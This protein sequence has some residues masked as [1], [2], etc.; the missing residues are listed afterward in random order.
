VSII[1]TGGGGGGGGGHDDDKLT[2]YYR[3]GDADGFGDPVAFLESASQAQGYVTDNTDCNDTDAAVNPGAVEACSDGIDNDCDGQIDEGCTTCTDADADGYY[4][5]TGCGTAVDC[6]DANAAVR[7]GAAEV[8]KDGID[9]DCD[10]QIDEDCAACTDAD[11]DGYYAEDGCGNAFLQGIDCDDDDAAVHP[12]AT[13]ICHDGIDNNCDGKI[14]EGCTSDPSDPSDCTDA[15]DDNYYAE[16]GCGNAIFQG[17]DCDDN[18]AAVYPGAKEVCDDGIDNDCDGKIDEGCTSDPSACTDA[19]RDGYF[20]EDGCGNAFL[21]GVDCD[22]DN[23]AV[24]PDATEVCDGIDN[25]CDGQVDENCSSGQPSCTDADRDGYY[26]EAGCGTAVDCNDANAAVHPGATEIYNDGIDNDCDGT[27]AGDYT[28][29]TFTNSLGMTFKRIPAGTFT[30]GVDSGHTPHQVTLTKDYYMQTTEVTQ[31][32]WRAVYGNNPSY[33]INCGDNCPV[34]Q[35][36][37]NTIQY[38]I[39]AMNRRGEGTYRLP[40]EAEWEYACRAGSTTSFANGPMTSAFGLCGYDP[41]LNVM[42]WYCYNSTVTYAGCENISVLLG[43]PCAGPHPVAQKRANVWGLY[44]MHGNVWE[45]CSDFYGLYPSGSV[46][47]PK[48]PSTGTS[49][50]YRGGSWA[51]FAEECRSA[52][53]HGT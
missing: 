25:D 27:A 43:P 41:N 21:Q 6:N 15:D 17:V 13:E 38:F 34:E 5:E 14:D 28:L 53:R 7:P 47:D 49:R 40:T 30:M 44:D 52:P 51:D 46:V 36:S 19:D 24:H 3:D 2:T 10:G 22:D 11:D 32:Q 37:W 42:G 31:S 12:D 18:D 35:V 4:A 26:A 33:F 48:G 23:P 1:G 16:D 20:V 29:G 9:N 45:F 50:V 8:C 39:T